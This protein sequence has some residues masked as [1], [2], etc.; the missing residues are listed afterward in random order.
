M[1]NGDKQKCC[2]YNFVQCNYI[3][4]FDTCVFVVAVKQSA[5]FSI[6]YLLTQLTCNLR[7]PKQTFWGER[8]K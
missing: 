6:L 4:L 2:I 8:G 1:K 5:L 7:R 3:G